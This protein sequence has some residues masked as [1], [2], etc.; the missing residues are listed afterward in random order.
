[1]PEEQEP[2]VTDGALASA[3]QDLADTTTPKEEPPVIEKKNKSNGWIWTILAFLGGLTFGV[4]IGFLI[5]GTGDKV[6]Q[7]EMEVA[8]TVTPTVVPTSSPTPTMAKVDRGS[9][10]VKVLNGTGGKGVAA[11]AKTFLESLGYK[12]IAVGNAEKETYEKTEISVKKN[13]NN[14][15]ETLKADLGS[16]YSVSDTMVMLEDVSE[17]DVVITIGK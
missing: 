6:Q 15:F 8:E 5:W 3:I 10:K 2:K 11:L 7:N 12:S 9:L 14:V 1:M 16:K 4:F 17:Y 13:K